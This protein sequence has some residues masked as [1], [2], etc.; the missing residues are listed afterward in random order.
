[1]SKENK[2][3]E[4]F[5]K[6]TKKELE[7]IL[8]SDM[9]VD[10]AKKAANHIIINEK[11]K[12]VTPIENIIKVKKL[13][14]RKKTIKTD[15]QQFLKV[16]RYREF[17]SLLCSVSFLVCLISIRGYYPN[18]NFLNS[19]SNTVLNIFLFI[20]FLLSNHIFYKLEHKRS[21]NFIGR[22]IINFT[23]FLMYYLLSVFVEINNKF[24]I[25]IIII[26]IMFTIL[27]EL[28]FSWINK[29]LKFF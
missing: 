2:F 23:F 6:K 28:F 21:N 12:R 25:E 7:H 26:F 3:I 9:Y 5:S 8:Q 24:E 13:K 15:L 18:L 4:K 22:L 29:Y 19:S 27:I 20:C 10:K 11:Y 1:M 14:T 17:Y 16:L